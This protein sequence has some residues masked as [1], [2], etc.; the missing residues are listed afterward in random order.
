MSYFTPTGFVKVNGEWE[1]T[2]YSKT[3]V[4]VPLGRLFHCNGND[5]VK[6]STRT[7]RMLTNGR[8]FYFRSGEPVHPIAN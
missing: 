7:A 5:Y 3:F 8:V 2:M 4:E 6:Q 1:R